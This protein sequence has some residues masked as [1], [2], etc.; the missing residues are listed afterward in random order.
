MVNT[1]IEG[2]AGRR[3]LVTGARGFIGS[4]LVKRL[5]AT[6]CVLIRGSRTPLDPISR[7]QA[8]CEALI[9]NP[10]DPEFWRQAINEAGVDL[11]FHLAGQTSAYAAE[12]DLDADDRA[13]VAPVRHLIEACRAAAHPVDALIAGTVTQA[14]LTERLPVNEDWPDAPITVYDHHKLEAE[15]NI[16]QASRD[17]ILRGTCLRLPNIYG[18]GGGVGSQDRGVLN[19]I[20]ARS[21]AGQPITVYGKGSEVRDYLFI[22]DIVEAFVLTSLAMENAAGRHFVTGTGTGHSLRQAFE[23]V[24]ARAEAATGA[25]VQVE[26]A[27]WPDGMLAIERRNFIADPTAIREATG[28]QASV[29]LSEGIDRT[30]KRLQRETA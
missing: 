12:A 14:G 23:L 11:V 10:S 17:T 8:T 26:N 22:D 2:L 24:A 9:G 19:K 6:D 21:I 1:V 16:E 18:P 29:S 13:N 7:R 30:I 28:W 27:P 15:R 25:A 5:A 20:I 4:A 3:I